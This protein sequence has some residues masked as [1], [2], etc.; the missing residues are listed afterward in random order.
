MMKANFHIFWLYCILSVMLLTGCNGFLIHQFPGQDG[1][2]PVD[3]TLVNLNIRITPCPLFTFR[4]DVPLEVETSDYYPVGDCSAR[5]ILEVRVNESFN[6]DLV[7]RE[8]FTTTADQVSE[9]IER[10]FTLHSFKYK[11]IVWQDL[12]DSSAPAADFWYYTEPLTAIKVL[13]RDV[14][15]GGNDSKQVSSAGQE[16]DLTPYRDDWNIQLD[17]EVPLI[18]PQSKYIIVSTDLK[19]FTKSY[20][21]NNPT[22]ADLTPEQI[23]E[24]CKM[25]VNYNGYLPTGY[26]AST[27]L[28]NDSQ[29][30]YGY[31]FKVVTIGEELAIVAF[32]YVLTGASSTSVNVGMTLYDEDGTVLNSVS[33]LNIPLT[34]NKITV[35]KGEYLTK[36]YGGGVGIDSDFDGEFNVIVP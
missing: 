11:V 12:T 9:V 32:D 6:T 30:G 26:N 8:T 14:Y 16:I 21:I 15:A 25:K 13:E 33:S 17:V 36:V 2:E 35:L 7:Y 10:Q 19:K 1:G 18:R 22:K 5:F 34:R 28:L 20:A 31:D 29:G 24:Q 23:F 27:G 3:P 4:E